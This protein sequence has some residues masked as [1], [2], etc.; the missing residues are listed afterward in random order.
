MRWRGSA[1]IHPKVRDSITS[2]R[3]LSKSESLLG[4]F[5]YVCHT[6]WGDLERDPNLEIPSAT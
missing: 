2:Y 6:F 4:S 1:T 5:V 3:Q